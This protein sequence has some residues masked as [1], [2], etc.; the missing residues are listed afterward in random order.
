MNRKLI[1][2]I[3]AFLLGV[4]AMSP[5]A[6]SDVAV[7]KAADFQLDGPTEGYYYSVWLQHELGD[8]VF[9]PDDD[10]YYV[11]MSDYDNGFYRLRYIFDSECQYEDYGDICVEYEADI[12]TK[13]E[14]GRNNTYYAGISGSFRNPAVEFTVVDGWGDWR[15]P[16]MQDPLE[17]VEIDG[18]EYDI[19]HSVF[20]NNQGTG[21]EE[22]TDHFW[23]VRTKNAFGANYSG[24]VSGTVNLSKHMKVWSEYM[25]EINDALLS[26]AGFHAEGYRS[27]KM[28]VTVRN[29]ELTTEYDGS[30][31]EV[32]LGDANSDGTVNAADLACFIKYLLSKEDI[33]QPLAMDI[34]KDGVITVADLI[35]MKSYILNS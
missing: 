23:S 3:T 16:G 17:T 4:S 24:K 20:I 33:E 5:W 9:D 1:S 21:E 19:F 18:V 14:S 15:P 26:D 29:F 7:V 22:L 10:P 25:P 11:V 34:D 35:F 6:F 28:E 8:L 2:G 12:K 27:G 13:S 30:E 31:D 32:L